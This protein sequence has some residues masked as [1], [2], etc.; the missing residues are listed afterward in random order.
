MVPFTLSSLNLFNYYSLPNTFSID[1]INLLNK[2]ILSLPSQEGTADFNDDRGRKSIIK[3]IPNSPEFLGL[4]DI[5]KEFILTINTNFWGFDITYSNDLIQ[6]TEYHSSDIGKYDWHVDIN[7]TSSRK[8]SLVI[9]LSDP[10]EYEG[11]EL[12]IKDYTHKEKI[13]SIPKQ[14]GLVTIFPSYMWHRV[15]PITKGTRKSLVWW[16]GGT[17]FR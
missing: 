6:Y 3:W 7:R 17:P 11:G 12:Q 4:Y 14:Q 1:N 10:N 16:V 9:Q 15:T 13:S 2:L 5:L 8:L